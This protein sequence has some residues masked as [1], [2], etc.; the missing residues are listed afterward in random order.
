MFLAGWS[1][2][3][4][5]FYQLRSQDVFYFLVSKYSSSGTSSYHCTRFFLSLARFISRN[6]IFFDA[7]V[8]ES[9]S[10]ISILHP[11]YKKGYIFCKLIWQLASV[12]KFLNI[13]ANFLVEYSEDKENSVSSTSTSSTCF[14]FSSSS[15]SFLLLLLFCS[16]W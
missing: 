1:F 6:I 11:W 7:I 2:S 4:Y 8:I 3:Q 15:S 10:M 9:V 16:L 5:Q 14:S 13:V 12:L